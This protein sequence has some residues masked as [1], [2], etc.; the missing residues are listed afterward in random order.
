MDLFVVLVLAFANT[1]TFFFELKKNS[2]K[3]FKKKR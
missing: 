3:K 2:E 1:K